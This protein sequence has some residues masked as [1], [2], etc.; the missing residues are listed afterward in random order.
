MAEV[1]DQQQRQEASQQREEVYDNG[2]MP[3]LDV[4]TKSWREKGRENVPPPAALAPPPM[5]SHGPIRSTP[6]S[7]M[8]FILLQRAHLGGAETEGSARPMAIS[9]K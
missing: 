7:P 1:T 9:K 4:Q 5:S 3:H 2:A 8:A 6:S